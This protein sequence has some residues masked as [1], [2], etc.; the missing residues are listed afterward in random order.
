MDVSEPP[1]GAPVSE[2][3]PKLAPGFLSRQVRRVRSYEVVFHAKARET[4]PLR[5]VPGKPSR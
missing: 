4:Q 1:V 5:S 2:T 3:R